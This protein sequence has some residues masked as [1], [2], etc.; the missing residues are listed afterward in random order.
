[1][2]FKER[3]NAKAQMRITAID[4]FE[5]VISFTVDAPDIFLS[6]KKLYW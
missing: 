6:G 1:M 5:Q 3:A 2:E 4:A